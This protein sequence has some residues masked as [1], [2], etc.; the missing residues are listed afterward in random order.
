MTKSWDLLQIYILMYMFI[1][2]QLTSN[3]DVSLLLRT[4]SDTVYGCSVFIYYYYL[5]I[6]ICTIIS[7]ID[8]PL[9]VVLCCITQRT[10]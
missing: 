5:Q 8:L 3:G 9:L 4:Q 10:F 6:S 2:I 7:S 1:I